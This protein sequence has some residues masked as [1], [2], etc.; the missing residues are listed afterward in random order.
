MIRF[1]INIQMISLLQNSDEYMY[2]NFYL[3]YVTLWKI[4]F[5]TIV[6]ILW[7]YMKMIFKSTK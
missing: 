7:K 3:P 1:N 6:V 4:I 5:T 2:E